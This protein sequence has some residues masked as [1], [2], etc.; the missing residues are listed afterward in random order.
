MSNLP[1]IVVTAAGAQPQSPS[2]ILAQLIA[3]VS[4]QVPGY[5]ANLPA[6]LIED[7]SSTEVAGVSLCDQAAVDLINSL[8]PYSANPFLV[9]Q[10]GNVYGVTQGVGSNTSVDVVFSG[11]PGFVIGQGFTVSDG[12]FQYV[13]Q[14]GGIIASDGQTLP[15]FALATQT[16]T[17]AVPQNTV[18]TLKTSVPMGY[19]VTVTNPQAGTPST[20]PQTLPEYQ[21]Q[22]IQAGRAPSQG[23]PT[24]LK[25]LVQAVPGVQ[26][27]LV[28][29][30]QA[31]GGWEVLV[32]G[33]DPYL[34][35]YAIYYAL[36]DINN[37][38]GSS[39]LVTNIT[40]ANP[41]VVTTNLNHGYTTGQT[42][43]M[44][45]VVG[46]TGVN[47]I[48]YTVTVIDEKSFSI[49]VPTTGFGAYV[50]GGIVTPNLRNASASVNDF[51]N[52][53]NVPF[54]LPPQQIV[55][56][57]LTWNTT[58]TNFVSGTAVA[59]LGVPALVSYINSI[60]VGAAIN[61][62]E[63]QET[64]QLS[65]AAILPPQLLT[66]MVFSVSINGIGTAPATGTGIIA[67]DPES[68]FQATATSVTVVQG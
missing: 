36:F 15:L 6:S 47:G 53:Y 35:A 62:F 29:V 46:M 58:A 20:G 57:E 27:R 55:A 24:Y 30:L 61:L 7:V 50:S 4:A 37:L 51:P 31:N 34:V 43:Q 17:W 22:V 67:G 33:G 18:T 66:R 25:S 54:V 56:I 45:G 68:Y 40:Q 9:T 44:N 65:I 8:S 41:G 49:G 64:F 59:Q 63:L 60:P 1:S 10:L 3:L 48:T 5:T 23:M 38:V 11:P 16:G 39:L 14:T 12:T 26:A 32:G 13:V 21:V 42:A 52:T 2:A 19:S 28:S